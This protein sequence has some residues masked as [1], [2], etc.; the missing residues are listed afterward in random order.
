ME[1]IH[2]AEMKTLHFFIW[3]KILKINLQLANIF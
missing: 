2:Y 3:N 1:T